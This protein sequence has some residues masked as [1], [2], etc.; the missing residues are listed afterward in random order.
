[1]G[2][3]DLEDRVGPAGGA[4]ITLADEQLEVNLWLQREKG[5]FKHFFYQR[6]FAFATLS[7][8]VANG[9]FDKVHPWSQ[10]VDSL[11]LRNLDREKK[12]MFPHQLQD[13]TSSNYYE[14]ELWSK[15]R[16][17][18]KLLQDTTEE[19]SPGNAF[20]SFCPPS[21]VLG[22]LHA[23]FFISQSPTQVPRQLLL[24]CPICSDE[25]KQP[26]SSDF[27]FFCSTWKFP[28]ALCWKMSV[29]PMW[30][31]FSGLQ[32]SVTVVYNN[33]SGGQHF[34]L[35]HGV[36]FLLIRLEWLMLWWET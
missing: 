6:T 17:I 20:F 12:N 19:E 9:S 24:I 31:R 18:I 16:R 36:F 10:W 33:M 13:D 27:F 5:A 3:E 23:Y 22:S 15:I 7:R 25:C 30:C 14:T 11:V 21:L 29:Q 32:S 2:R 1:M 28:W 35:H 26:L 4:N 8:E 34:L